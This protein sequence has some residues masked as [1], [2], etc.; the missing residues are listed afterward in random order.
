MENK[1][2]IDLSIKFGLD[3]AEVSKIVDTMY[4]CG[5]TQVD[6]AE[7]QKIAN[8]VCSNGLLDKP[9]EELLEDLKATGFVAE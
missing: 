3:S 4:Q 5:I 6:S 8:Y 1:F 9:A 2:L 7:A